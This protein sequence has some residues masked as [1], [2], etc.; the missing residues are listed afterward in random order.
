MYLYITNW[1][2]W[3]PTIILFYAK[4]V[5]LRFDKKCSQNTQI[6]VWIQTARHTKLGSSR[7]STITPPPTKKKLFPSNLAMLNIPSCLH[8]DSINVMTWR[9]KIMCKDYML[10]GGFPFWQSKKFSKCTPGFLILLI[11]FIFLFS[12]GLFQR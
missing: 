7:S 5:L 4:E 1:S 9:D 3:D 12:I 2:N 11:D 8:F 6:Q 10:F